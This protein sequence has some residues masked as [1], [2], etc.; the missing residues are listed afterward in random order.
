VKKSIEVSRIDER[1][2]ELI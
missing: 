1:Y 2:R